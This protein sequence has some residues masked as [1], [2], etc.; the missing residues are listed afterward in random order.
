MLDVNDARD[1]FALHFIFMPVIQQQLD[2]FRHGWAHH[3]LRTEQYRTPQQLWILGL[4]Q[5][6]S[7]DPFHA[8]ITGMSEVSDLTA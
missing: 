1:L 6:Q 4:H 8:A 3:T 2:L 7:S 5:V